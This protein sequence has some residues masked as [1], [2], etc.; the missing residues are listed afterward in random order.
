MPALASD[1]RKQL[2]SV[3]IQARDMAEAAARSALKKRAVD[4]AEPFAHFSAE[5]KELRNRLR[6][7]GR[8]A[9][10]MRE[11]Q[12]A[13]DRPT[14]PGARLRILAPDAVRPVPGREP[15]ADAPGRRGGQ[16]GGMRGTGHGATRRPRTASSWRP[17]T[18]ARCCRRFS[19]PTTCCWR[20]SSPRINDWRWRSCWRA[21]RP[22][23]S[24][25]TTAWGGS[26]SSG[27]PRR[28]TRSTRAARR[29]T[30]ARFPP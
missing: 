17:A 5:E 22:R 24:S 12:D 2:E 15:P 11:R 27:R 13:G 14:H 1:L 21:C 7:R 19:A 23:S 16:P 10:D 4:A 26:T 29:S 30:G 28:R 3:I 18:P 25:P 8:Q 9:G 20:S 6:A